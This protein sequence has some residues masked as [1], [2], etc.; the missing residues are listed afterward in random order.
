MTPCI[1]RD[2]IC[3]KPHSASGPVIVQLD[4][5][6][7]WFLLAAAERWEKALE[8]AEDSY[9]LPFVR[10]GEQTLR[11]AM[12]GRPQPTRTR[13]DILRE[14]SDAE[15]EMALERAA[16]IVDADPE[17]PWGVS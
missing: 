6:E 1:C 12:F 3:P 17:Y 10:R 13:E 9:S 7:A 8:G 16:R 5:M 4:F 11:A 15:Y 2:P 14:K